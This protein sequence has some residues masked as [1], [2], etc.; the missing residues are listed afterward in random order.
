MPTQGRTTLKTYFNTDDIP[1]ESNFVDLIDS[2]A[3]TTE[4]VT[5][6]ESLTGL[7][8]LGSAAATNTTAYATSAQG[9][10]ASTAVQPAA[11]SA[12]VTQVDFVDA[13]NIDAASWVSQLGLVIGTNVQA[14]DAELSAIAG[15]V[16]A[17]NQLP[18]FT[19]SGAAALTSL[20]AAG[21]AILDDADAAAQR[22]T[23]GLAIGTDVQAYR[24]AL[25][26]SPASDP[27]G[28]TGAD[29]VTNIIS[30]TQAEYDAITPNATTFYI[31]TD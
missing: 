7:P 19:G 30:L 18:Y 22:T 11:L 6:Y 9:A 15:L 4:I 23:M 29:A 31:I 21:R 3:L 28:V 14:Q 13:V 25:L 10:L 2:F 12:Y 1:T 16:S 5:A 20:T 27:T 8:T 26:S 17:A 24:A